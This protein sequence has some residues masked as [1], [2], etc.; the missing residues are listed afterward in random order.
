MTLLAKRVS[1]ALFALLR[2]LADSRPEATALRGVESALNAWMKSTRS[3][4]ALLDGPVSAH[5]Q[6]EFRA[7]AARHPE[8]LG[9]APQGWFDV[10]HALLSLAR[11][12][13]ASRP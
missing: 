8:G 11:A 12:L 4:A 7:L 2:I 5:L 10:M 1:D 13:D 3:E 6:T 9:A